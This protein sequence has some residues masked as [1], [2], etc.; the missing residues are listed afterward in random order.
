MVARVRLQPCSTRA[1]RLAHRTGRGGVFR[2]RGAEGVD[3]PSR[4]AKHRAEVLQPGN[5][6]PNP[7]PHSRIGPV[8]P[9]VNPPALSA[10]NETVAPTR[11]KVQ[12]SGG[13][14]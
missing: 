12:E 5:H 6:Q 13:G 11:V 14:E 1:R 3:K 2:A 10:T 7:K 9:R 4:E 8:R